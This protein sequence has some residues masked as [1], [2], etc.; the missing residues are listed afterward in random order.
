MPEMGGVFSS[1]QFVVALSRCLKYYKVIH[2]SFLCFCLVCCL[3]VPSIYL[4]PEKTTGDGL[5]FTKRKG[6]PLT[7][8]HQNPKTGEAGAQMWLTKDQN[9]TP[10]YRGL[11]RGTNCS[12]HE[13]WVQKLVPN[14]C[15]ALGFFHSL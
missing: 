9:E 1:C 10:F 12:E 11:L 5:N 3:L 4:T 7:H 14:T 15:G 2:C 13:H 6:S 8:Y